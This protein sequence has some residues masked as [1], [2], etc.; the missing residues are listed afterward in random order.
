MKSKKQNKIMKSNG[1][2]SLIKWSKFMVWRKTKDS[3]TI[4][5]IK[6]IFLFLVRK[7]I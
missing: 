4:I 1:S 3:P 6:K 5:I 2:F 7:Q